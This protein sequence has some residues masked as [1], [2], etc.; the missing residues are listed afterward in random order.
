MHQIRG[1]LVRHGG[2]GAF[3][4]YLPRMRKNPNS[5]ERMRALC[6]ISDGFD[7]AMYDLRLR[8]LGDIEAGS[9]QH[10]AYQGLIRNINVSIDDVE[11]VVELLS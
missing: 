7:L 3:V 6:E 9:T 10:G 11:S 8:G 2:H 5:L 4:L 1:R